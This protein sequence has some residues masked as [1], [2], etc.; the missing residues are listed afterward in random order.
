MNDYVKLDYFEDSVIQ[1]SLETVKED[2]NTFIQTVSI[3][4]PELKKV[5]TNTVTET[6]TQISGNICSSFSDLYKYYLRDQLFETEDVKITASVPEL[7]LFRDIFNYSL[8]LPTPPLLVSRTFGSYVQHKDLQGDFIWAPD[9]RVADF[10]SNELRLRLPNT[11]EL[12][13]NPVSSEGNTRLHELQCDS[14][15]AIQDFQSDQC[16]NTYYLT[17][18]FSTEMYYAIKSSDKQ[19]VVVKDSVSDNIPSLLS[20]SNVTLISVGNAYRRD[21][22]SNMDE[23]DYKVSY[24]KVSR[25]PSFFTKVKQKLNTVKIPVFN[26]IQDSFATKDSFYV[27]IPVSYNNTRGYLNRSVLN[28]QYNYLKAD[29]YTK[30]QNMINSQTDSLFTI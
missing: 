10:I 6:S 26:G 1:L 25:V 30:M 15:T 21:F 22:S 12:N 27:S 4:T 2:N 5:I 9:H 17:D 29:S 3:K 28:T 7:T 11:I 14:L 8:P 19:F 20:A 23:T 13:Y 16:A 24:D 18:E